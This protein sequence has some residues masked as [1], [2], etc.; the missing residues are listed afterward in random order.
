MSS[1]EH[2]DKINDLKHNTWD[3]NSNN[4]VMQAKFAYY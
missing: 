3:C 2:G 1:K 4:N